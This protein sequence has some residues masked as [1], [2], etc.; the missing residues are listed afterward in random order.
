MNSESYKIIISLSHHRISFEYWLRDAED[1]LA[2]MPNMTWPAPLA[3][4]CSQIGIEIGDAAVRAV[5]AG[6]SNA[7]DN[8]FERLPKDETY[9]IGGQRKPLRYLLLD[10]A[11]SIFADFFKNVLFGSKG[12]LSDNRATMP[13]TLVCESDIRPNERALLFDLFKGSGYNRFKVVEYNT[14]IER[15]IHSTL[16]EEY[17][18]EKVLVAWTEGVDLSFSL[19]DARNVS[20]CHQ[21][22]YSGLGVDPRLE[23]VKSLI[24]DR[25]KGQNPWLLY[26]REYE[27]I[28][29]AAAD[30]LNTTVPLVNDTLILSDGVAYY[31]SLNRTVVNNLQCNEGDSI[32]VKLEELLRRNNITNRNKILLLLRGIAAG[33]VFFEQTICQGFSNTIRSDRKLRDNT[34]RLLIADPNPP[35]VQGSESDSGAI[36]PILHNKRESLKGLKRRWREV[37]AQ[38]YGFVKGRRKDDALQLLNAFKDECAKADCTKDIIIE[39][40]EII[41]SIESVTSP[42]SPDSSTIKRLE[43]EWRELRATAKGKIR[44]G[45]VNEAVKIYSDFIKQ[46]AD[47]SGADDL[48]ETV[49]SELFSLSKAKGDTQLQSCEKHYGGERHSNGKWIGGISDAGGNDDLRTVDGKKH[50]K[51]IEE[52][53]TSAKSVDNGA[54]L[55]AAGK[56]KEARDW[57]RASCNNEK[58]RILT[59]L[60]RSQKGIELRKKSVEEC[61]RTKNVDQIKRIISELKIYIE[62]SNQVNFDC[63]EYK[64]LLSEYNKLIK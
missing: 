62:Q 24:W 60:I 12:S 51:S 64:K 54:K 37:K 63:T 4:Y 32:R 52:K 25:I 13:V 20:E 36:L 35:I 38:S 42:S 27:T 59:N 2:P 19:F 61:K 43:R 48:I 55:I 28:S 7:F 16:A 41:S 9:L 1:K 50:Q 47:I 45:Q 23:Y 57:Y 33:N 21:E 18:C 10:A 34:M 39:V 40:N 15:Y 11:E 29:K 8:Y 56:L 53:I 6:I 26:S 5:H 46:I 14:F 17:A 49:Q 58:A 3:F 22:C 30:F 44:T 31:Y